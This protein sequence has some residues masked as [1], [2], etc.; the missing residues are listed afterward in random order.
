MKFIIRRAV[1]L[2]M[3]CFFLLRGSAQSGPVAIPFG[4]N[5]WSN[6]PTG[7]AIT[8]AGIS[9]W[10]DAA[11]SFTLYYR[12]TGPLP[13]HAWIYCSVPSGKSRIRVSPGRVGMN[14]GIEVSAA[15]E[16]GKELEVAGAGLQRYDAGSWDIRDT[17]YQAIRVEGVSRTGEI[18]ADIQRIELSGEGLQGPLAGAAGD[19]QGAA[20]GAGQGTATNA[21]Q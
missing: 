7:G 1:V 8:N 11:T 13:V 4:G 3:A 16:S 10:T 14:G 20:A 21:V 19:R 12:V 17:G 15:G 9:G 18:F 6:R 2:G 5:A